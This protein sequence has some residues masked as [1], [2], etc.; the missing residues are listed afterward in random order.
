MLKT[1]F[2]KIIKSILVKLNLIRLFYLFAPQGRLVILNYHRISEKQEEKSLSAFEIGV[3][4]EKFEKEMR[5]LNRNFSIIPFSSA[6][7]LLKNGGDWPRLPVVI[8]FDDGYRDIYLNAF[9]VLEKFNLPAI[10]FI[11]TRMVEKGDPFWWDELESL[12]EHNHLEEIKL[13]LKNCSSPEYD[14]DLGKV[15][16]IQDKRV[17]LENLIEQI[18]KIK[19]RYRDELLTKLRP[20]LK[21]EKE[22]KREVL[23]WDEIKKLRK[24]RIEFG[25]HTHNHYLLTFE[26]QKTIIEELKISRQKL[27]ENLAEK[28][29]FLSYPSGLSNPEIEKSAKEFGYKAGCSNS[30]GF[31]HKGTDFF[32]LKRLSLEESQSLDD[33]KISLGRLFGALP[34]LK[35]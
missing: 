29:E 11:S 1:F 12:I 25:S 34:F 24:N 5:Y 16:A 28:I 26:D 35:D 8:S 6:I 10:V 27:E 18:K 20:L 13:A 23:S 14:L 3:T 33:F 22:V 19:G 32:Y 7:K 31:N 4:R 9:P 17:F 15:V 30:Y 2:K 21:S